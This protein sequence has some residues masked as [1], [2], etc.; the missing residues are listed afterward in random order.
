V[1]PGAAGAPLSERA[2]TFAAIAAAIGFLAPAGAVVA[3]AAPL[4]LLTDME[5]GPLVGAVSASAALLLVAA[6]PPRAL[7]AGALVVA[8][9]APS[10]ACARWLDGAPIET[11]VVELAA[12]AL[13]ALLALGCG[14]IATGSVAGLLAAA[15]SGLPPLLLAGSRIVDPHSSPPEALVSAAAFSPIVAAAR[16]DLISLAFAAVPAVLA[17]AGGVTVRRL[18]HAR[19]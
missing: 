7:A 19:R 15:V 10:L 14:A 2:G 5:Y 16:G 12:V 8:G 6:A 4:A 11:S 13:G 1:G 3:R 17:A 9:A 18:Q